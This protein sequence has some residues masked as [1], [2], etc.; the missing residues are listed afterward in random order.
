V[1][2]NNLIE[3]TGWGVLA[4]SSGIQPLAESVLRLDGFFAAWESQIVPLDG[5]LSVPDHVN[6]DMLI[7]K[8]SATAR[9]Q[10][11]VLDRIFFAI[12]CLI[13]RFHE[14]VLPTRL[15]TSELTQGAQRAAAV[16]LLQR[17][18]DSLGYADDTAY[19]REPK[20]KR[21][22]QNL[23]RYLLNLLVKEQRLQDILGTF[24]ATERP[25]YVKRI[26][27]LAI[28]LYCSRNF[29]PESHAGVTA[30]N[31]LVQLHES[32]QQ[33]GRNLAC[34]EVRSILARTL[35]IDKRIGSRI[36]DLT[37]LA[38]AL[39]DPIRAVID[40][41]KWKGNA[42]GIKMRVD[43][44]KT[45]IRVLN[46]ELQ[47][48][49][50]SD[51]GTLAGPVSKVGAPSTIDDDN[52]E[53]AEATEHEGGEF[54]ATGRTLAEMEAEMEAALHNPV[55]RRYLVRWIRQHRYEQS[56]T[57]NL[58]A[59]DKI[60]VLRILKRNP[61]SDVREVL[62]DEVCLALSQ[63]N[64]SSLEKGSEL[65][66][67]HNQNSNSKVLKTV[68][69]SRGKGSPIGWIKSLRQAAEGLT[70]AFEA[71]RARLD[72]SDQIGEELIQITEQSRQLIITANEFDKEH[73]AVIDA[74][75]KKKAAKAQ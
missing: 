8:R 20:F 5:P 75:F 22:H 68:L 61:V 30:R 39:G 57:R 35:S 64:D 45:Y 37:R 51:F 28:C 69:G 10:L 60:G 31:D 46:G 27:T 65:L 18:P 74:Y 40:A 24:E 53:D 43:I 3:A 70:D 13:D 2:L 26:I 34:A 71:L 11:Y 42:L 36:Q 14:T 62:L 56:A 67:C 58:M 9:S 48:S 66:L 73:K 63:V 29:N 54:K 16:A 38:A 44:P 12:I 19:W 49:G 50:T 1:L 21:I 6:S 33:L 52:Q 4:P 41:L 47:M 17:N 23:R 32:L 7:C 55:I 25:F 59:T 15:L 72:Q